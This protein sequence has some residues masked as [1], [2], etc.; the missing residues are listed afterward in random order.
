MASC[1]QGRV[2]DEATV[3]HDLLTV[4]FK[5]PDISSQNDEETRAGRGTWMIKGEERGREEGSGRRVV[6]KEGG[7]DE[8]SRAARVS[9]QILSHS[10]V[11]SQPLVSLIEKQQPAYF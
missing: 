5:G 2:S 11:T 3:W 4:S 8:G 10:R 6:G 1:S 9:S 7:G